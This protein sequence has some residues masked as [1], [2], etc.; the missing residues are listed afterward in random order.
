MWGRKA[1][2]LRQRCIDSSVAMI[3]TVSLQLFCLEKEITSEVEI[4]G[5]KLA[6][7]MQSESLLQ[8]HQ[9]IQGNVVMKKYLIVL[10]ILL[11]GCGL[12]VGFSIPDRINYAINKMNSYRDDKYSISYTELEE[13]T[14]KLD[15]STYKK[16]TLEIY[17]C[18][19]ILLEI[20]DIVFTGDGYDVMFISTG[21]S[22]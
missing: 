9:V 17:N 5:G 12:I 10:L 16:E 11:G 14:L 22:N 20:E 13:K 18:K 2:S 15:F 3:R 19:G 6:D 8:I 7:W 1:R 4:D 21:K